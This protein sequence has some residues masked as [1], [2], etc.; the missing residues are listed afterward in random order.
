MDLAG[1]PIYKTPTKQYYKDT[2]TFFL[3]VFSYDIKNSLDGLNNYIEDIKKL[4]PNP[5][6]ILIGNKK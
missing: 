2:K 4:N 3:V 5:N 1:L 6:F